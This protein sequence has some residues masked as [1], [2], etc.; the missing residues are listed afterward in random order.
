MPLTW[1]NVTCIPT[2]MLGLLR[3]WVTWHPDQACRHPCK[4]QPLEAGP[5]SVIGVDL[6]CKLLLP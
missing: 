1:P 2:H 3:V 4:L 6:H 5:S